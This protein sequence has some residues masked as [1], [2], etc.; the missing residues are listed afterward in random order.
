V[1]QLWESKIATESNFDMKRF[2]LT[3]L[4]A[5][6]R[7]GFQSP[8]YGTPNNNITL[9][10]CCRLVVHITDAIVGKRAQKMVIHTAVGITETAFAH[11]CYRQVLPVTSI[12]AQKPNLEIRSILESNQRTFKTI[13][14]NQNDPCD[15]RILKPVT[16]N[17]TRRRDC[18]DKTV[19]DVRRSNVIE[20]HS[21]IRFSQS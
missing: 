10:F 18:L 9:V 1:S 13:L 16:K 2:Y 4:V 20:P 17:V 14:T 15:Q 11:D 21:N 6:K 8:K 19:D 3:R 12:A 5:L 7:P